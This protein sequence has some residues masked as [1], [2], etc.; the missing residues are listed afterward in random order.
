MTL[1]NFVD[2][3]ERLRRHLGLEDFVLYGHSWG[4]MLGIDYY[5]KYTDEVKA[6]IFSSPLF[7]TRS[8]IADADS[9]INTLPDSVQ[10]TIHYHESIGDYENSAY[11]TA[12]E[13]YYAQY[14]T[15]KPRAK[16]DRSHLNLS[17]GSNVYRYMRGPSEFNSTGTLR[18]CDRMDELQGSAVPT[19]LVC[20]EFDEASPRT[21]EGYSKMIP[22]SRFEVIPDA[23]HSTLNDNP[24]AMLSVIGD[25]LNSV[26]N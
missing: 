20:G 2:Q 7:S 17:A 15:R 6:I 16:V 5:L 19:L 23:A 18:E 4:T 9:L 10:Q 25:F 26:A 3:T 24:Q 14:V 8:W 11:Q 22:K 12:T 21:V 1:E 13:L